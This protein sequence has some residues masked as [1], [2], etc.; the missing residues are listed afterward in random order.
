MGK[1]QKVEMSP[2]QREAHR[3]IGFA[4]EQM[5]EDMKTLYFQ[6]TT[7]VSCWLTQE[8]LVADMT[9]EEA[10]VQLAKNFMLPDHL[11]Q[12]RSVG[13]KIDQEVDEH[14]VGEDA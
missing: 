6:N 13:E 2:R 3:L 4:E 9:F 12:L 11:E 1:S 7:L 8:M 10:A 5:S 14:T